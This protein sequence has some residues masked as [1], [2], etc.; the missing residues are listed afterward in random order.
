MFARMSNLL[1]R[2]SGSKTFL[3][4]CYSTPPLNMFTCFFLGSI[5]HAFYVPTTSSFGLHSIF[6]LIAHPLPPTSL[7]PALFAWTLNVGLMDKRSIQRNFKEDT[8]CFIEKNETISIW[9]FYIAGMLM[10][11]RDWLQSCA[12]RSETCRE[13]KSSGLPR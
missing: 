6:F 5:I 13:E 12:L 2:E 10:L 4:Q 1:S 8:C 11:R 7:L 9:S 3:I